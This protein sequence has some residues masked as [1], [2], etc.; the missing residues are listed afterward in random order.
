MN[1]YW[2]SW[3]SSKALGP[4]ELHSPWW[5]SGYVCDSENTP[6]ICAAVRAPDEHGARELV[7]KS[8]DKRP[9][10]LDWRFCESRDPNWCPYGDRF[11]RAEWMKW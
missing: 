6:T 7:M 5:I 4:F 3:Y 10:K 1:N 9:E 8:Y 2:I 11:P